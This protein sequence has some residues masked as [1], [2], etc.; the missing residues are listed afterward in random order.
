[1]R[2]LLLLAGLGGLLYGIDTG[3]I[4]GALPLL[5]TTAA[6]SWK[7][8]PQQL[9]FVVAAVLLGSV[10]ASLGTGALA[11]L[12]GR[13]PV[14][15]LAGALFSLSI[16]V[17]AM[18][19]GYTALL[20]GRLL[21]GVSCGLIGVALPLYLAETLDPGRRGA[22]TA[23]FQLFL[24]A[25]LVAAAL[26]G[27]HY[28][29]AGP[30]GADRAWRAIFWACLAPG[31][32]FTGAALALRE[33]PRWPA[34]AAPR[35][36]LL[37][38]GH[39]R[40]F[41]LACAILACNQATGVNSVLAYGVTLLHR[42]GL[43][44]TAANRGDLALKGVNLVMTGVAVLLVDRLG[45]RSLLLLGSAGAC[46]ALA[47]AGAL[48]LGA[49]SGWLTADRAH[50]WLVAGCLSAFMGAFAVGP[51]VCVWLALSEL[52]P[53]RIRANGMSA[54]LLVNQLVATLIAAVFLPAVARHGYAAMLFAWAAGASVY[55]LIVLA[56]LP[57]T[58]G[59]TLEAIE[60]D[61]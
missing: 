19:G 25:G 53:A 44:G 49:E 54:A 40:P 45:R 47:A 27:L 22:G 14:L 61:W 56:F 8:G 50:G 29:G 2:P 6:V 55:F 57:E 30:A 34:P 37:C 5:A 20:L 13:K 39:V 4:A 52:L 38:R 59:R 35:G 41:L 26:I 17:I 36:P 3:I 7:L 60:A 12:L 32:L 9:S 16:P 15:V 48:F 58:R 1:M 33:S 42:A 23:V 10:L 24:T 11:D 21:Q 43:P 28:A 46:L 18:A 31:V 51:G